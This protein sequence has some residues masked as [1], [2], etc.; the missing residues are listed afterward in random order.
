M[1]GDSTTIDSLIPLSNFLA[2]TSLPGYV[3]V[4]MHFMKSTCPQ[5]GARCYPHFVDN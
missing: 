3:V 2:G 1:K 4:L 5:L